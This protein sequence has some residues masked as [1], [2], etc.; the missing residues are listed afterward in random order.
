VTASNGAD[1]SGGS[2]SLNMSGCTGGQFKY[3]A[4][5]SSIVLA[6]NTAYYVVTLEVNGGDRWYDSGTVSSTSAAA[7]NNSVY[8]NGTSWLPFNGANTSYVPPNFLY[9]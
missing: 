8:F 6:A 3:A 1:V 4:L 9:Q 7:V 5:P 2:I